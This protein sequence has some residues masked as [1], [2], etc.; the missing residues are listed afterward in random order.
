MYHN[1]WEQRSDLLQ[2]HQYTRMRV[3][4]GTIMLVLQSLQWISQL[5]ESVGIIVAGTYTRMRVL[6][7]TIMLV[8]Q[9]LHFCITTNGVD[10]QLA[11]VYVY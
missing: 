11:Y 1:H 4:H 2:V 6:L 7:G 3:L 9:N 10:R 8:L 5:L